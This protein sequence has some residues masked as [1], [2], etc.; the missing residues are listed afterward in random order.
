MVFH[1]AANCPTKIMAL[2]AVEE[3]ENRFWGTVRNHCYREFRE[4]GER[5]PGNLGFG[6]AESLGPS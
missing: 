5:Q 4:F 2:S 6:K 3:G 1:P